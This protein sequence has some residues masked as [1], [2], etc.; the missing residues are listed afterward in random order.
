VFV[1]RTNMSEFAFSGLG[2]NPHYGTPVNPF[3]PS[4][5]AGGSSS[6][7]ATSVALGHVEAA[8]GTDTGGSVRIPAAFCG[9]VGFKPTARRVPLDGSVPLSTSF[10]SIGPIARSVDCCVLIDGVVSRQTLDTTPRPLTGLRFGVTSD[11]V[12]DD[13]DETVSTAFNRA[14]GMLRRA[15]ASVERFAFPELHEVAGRLS[16][17]GITAAQA[18]AWHRE[19]V[20]RNAQG[21]DPR[22]LKRLRIGEGRSAADYIDLLAA[23]ERFVRN[24]RMRLARFNAW[25]MPTVATVPPEIAGIENDD[26]AFLAVNAN[27]LRNP[28]VVNFM[29]G[30]ALTLPCHNEDELPVGLSI[31]GPA[32]ADASILSIARSVEALLRAS[33]PV[34]AA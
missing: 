4:R 25:L 3:D 30:C 21:Y 27:V 31:C 12:S 7:A 9:L 13:L 23:R 1:G 16:L 18:W 14:I 15:G 19:H 33:V 10:D 29:D 32:L 5:L 22:V 28:S 24:A 17:A 6:G 8:L 11:Y 2:L 20:A 34:V 26:E